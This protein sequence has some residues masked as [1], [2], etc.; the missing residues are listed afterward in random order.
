MFDSQDA[1][2][3][4]GATCSGFGDAFA[5]RG[6][7]LNRTIEDA[8][9]AASA[10]SS[11]SCANLADP[12]HRAASASSRSSATP[13]ASS[14]RSRRPTRTCSRR[15]PT[16]SRR[17]RATRRRCKDTIAKSAADARRRRP[18]R[19]ASSARSSTHTAAFSQRPRRAPP[20]SCAARCRRSTARSR[21]ARRCTQR[22][23]AAQRA[24]LAGHAR[25]AAAT[26]PRRRRRNGALRGLTATVGTL[27]PQLRFL[28]PYVTVCNDWNYFWT[29]VAEHF[30]APDTTGSSQRALLN[31]A[32]ASQ[33][34]TASARS[35]ANEFAHGK[36]ALPGS[37]AHAVPARQRLRRRRSTPTA[38]PTASAGQ[39]G[40]MHGRQPAARQD[41]QGDPYQRVVD[42]RIPTPGSQSARPTSSSTRDGQRRRPEP[43]ARAGRRDV[44]RPR[45]AAT[46][47]T[48]RGRQP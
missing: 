36:G 45:P 47:S 13:R 1:R 23:V 38:T 2:G 15:W 18:S 31:M 30:S 6:A 11:R 48:S 24:T 39:R 46:A 29:F 14:R 7:D 16:R 27:Q 41:V 19:C 37:G 21:S 5:G 43:R 34:P 28:G 40:Y 4:A 3:V 25:R 32:P 20:T 10:T 8:A 42:R 44:H 12:R 9:A 35:G 26:S 22:S 17:S 33:A